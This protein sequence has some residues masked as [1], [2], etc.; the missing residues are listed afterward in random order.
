MAPRV[1]LTILAGQY[2]GTSQPELDCRFEKQRLLAAAE[3]YAKKIGVAV[4]DE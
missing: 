1:R 4:I 2:N 3:K